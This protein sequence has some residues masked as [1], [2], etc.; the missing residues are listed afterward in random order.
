[1]STRQVIEVSCDCLDPAHV[2][3]EAC[4][5]YR[6]VRTNSNTEARWT[7]LVQDAF[8][9]VT[10]PC[11]GYGGRPPGRKVA[12]DRCQACTDW[13]D[14]EAVARDTIA[15]LGLVEDNLAT[16]LTGIRK[17]LRIPSGS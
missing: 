12:G 11:A 9:V 2:E 13:G 15:A 6:S 5:N 7:A 10:E 4:G 8:S 14:P 17:V 1:M 16:A 3:G